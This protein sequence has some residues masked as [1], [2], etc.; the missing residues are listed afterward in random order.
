MGQINEARRGNVTREVAIISEKENISS[1]RL[2]KDIATG[3]TVILRNS[4]RLAKGFC[5]VGKGLKTKVNV[6]IGTSPQ[7]IDIKEEIQK[8]E[9]SQ[10]YE[11][12][13][14]MDLST[15]GDIDETRKIVLDKT[16]LPVGTV[17][18]YQAMIEAGHLT[19]LGA[20]AMLD[21]VQKHAQ[22]GVDFV[23]VH[24]GITRKCLKIIKKNPRVMSVV[25]RGGAFLMKWM[26]LTGGE[27]PLYSQ[28]DR[29]L[30]IAEE[31]DMVLSLG[32]GM[33]PGC[34]ADASDSLQLYEL[35][36]LAKLAKRALKRGVQVII[37]GPGHL[38]INHV[39]KNIKWQKKICKGAPFYVLGPV[40]TDIAPGYDHITGAIGGAIAASEGADFLCYVTPAEHLRLPTLDDIKEGLIATKIAAHVADIAKGVKGAKDKDLA[41]AKARAKRDWKQHFKCSIDPEKAKRFYL[42]RSSEDNDV[43]SMCGEFCSLKVM[44]KN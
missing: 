5:A 40:V 37:E 29:L 28:F 43:C 31:Y 11:A 35:K 25:S 19:N 2:M 32:D 4:K 36:T 3:K 38:P 12:D 22:D 9:L 24:S 1:K 42:S 16:F 8:I 33:R 44:E 41:I 23:T 20:D 15:G 18:I 10:L 30:D 34:I 39:K 13:A 27:N 7:C 17:P 6:N 26:E 14:I 21:V